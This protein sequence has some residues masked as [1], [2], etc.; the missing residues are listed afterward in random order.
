MNI[1]CQARKDLL[2]ITQL[3]ENAQLKVVR[4][5]ESGVRKQIPSEFYNASLNEI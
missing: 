5:Q 3:S 2:C 4:G 1:E